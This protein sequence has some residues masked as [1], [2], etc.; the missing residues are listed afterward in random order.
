MAVYKVRNGQSIYDIA[1]EI[2]GNVTGI[3]YLLEDNP[4]INLDTYLKTDL[5]IVVNPTSNTILDQNIANFFL[6]NPITNTETISKTLSLIGNYSS[7]EILTKNLLL[8]EYINESMWTFGGQL[9]MINY[10]DNSG[11]I[12]YDRVKFDRLFEINS[13]GDELELIFNYENFFV[14]QD[15]WTAIGNSINQQD[16]IS[17]VDHLI[18]LYD[19]NGDLLISHPTVVEQDVDINVKV[20]CEIDGNNKNYFFDVNG[21]EVESLN[22]GNKSFSVDMLGGLSAFGGSGLNGQI[23]YFRYNS[24]EYL[25]NEGMGFNVFKNNL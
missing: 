20:R 4:S 16:N 14:G 13:D 3:S 19:S 6:G 15:I 11:K 1:T 22:V 21:V 12:N 25:F 24:S 18:H 5:E 9:Q 8:E 23:K 17:V 7:G 2:Y 10:E